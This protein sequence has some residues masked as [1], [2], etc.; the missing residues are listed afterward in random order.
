MTIDKT[1]SKPPQC[2]TEGFRL[3]NANETV[4]EFV[5][6]V[7]WHAIAFTAFMGF[8]WAMLQAYQLSHFLIPVLLLIGLI[9]LLDVA[10]GVRRLMVIWWLRPGELTL[11]QYPLRL[12]ESCRFGYRRALRRGRTQ[13]PGKVSGH[14]HCYEWGKYKRESAYKTYT[15][16]LWKVEFPSCEVPVGTRRVEWTNH[17]NIPADG[18]PSFEAEHSGL[19]WELYVQLE[20]PGIA[21]N[22]SKFR[23]WI[24]PEV[25]GSCKYT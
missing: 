6:S 1:S 19:R 5:I 7:I 2:N 21:T 24:E 13:R 9:G 3:I 17:L 4:Q 22:K 11:P 14:L 12:G 15:H 8:L 25:V 23:L 20:L 18:P 10:W 16:T